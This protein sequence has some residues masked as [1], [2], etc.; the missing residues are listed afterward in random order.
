LLSDALHF[1]ISMNF[2][3]K[4]PKNAPSFQT[5]MEK[6]FGVALEFICLAS[7]IKKKVKL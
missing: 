4:K 1:A 5:L 2:K 6:D 7:N 3:L